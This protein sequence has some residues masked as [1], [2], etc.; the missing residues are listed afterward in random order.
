VRRAE[1]WTIADLLDF[2]YLLAFDA[3]SDDAALRARDRTIFEQ[4]IAPQLDSTRRSGRRFIF[5]RWLS[6]RRGA[7]GVAVPGAHFLAGW[8]TLLT[9]AALTGLALGVSLTAG[10]LHYRGDEP[11]NVSWFL[12]CTLGVQLLVLMVAAA[13]WL[14]RVATHWF[15]DFH[16]LRGLLAGL[17]WLC[18]AGL[19]Q[20]PGAQRESLRASL[21]ILGRKREI[22]GSVATWPFLI[23]TQLFGVTF[24]VGI[25]GTMVLHLAFT[26]MHFQWESTWVKSP[27]TAYRMVAGA[28]LPWRSFAPTPHPTLT[29]IEQSH[30]ID[31]SSFQRLLAAQDAQLG[32]LKSWWPFLCYSIAFYG[33]LVRGLLLVWSATSL[34]RALR[35]IPFD[36]QDCNALL[37]RLTGPVLQAQSE[38]TQLQVPAFSKSPSAHAAG[39]SFVLLAEG[40]AVDSEALRQFLQTN[41]RWELYQT[42][43]VQI[44]HPSGN[45]AALEEIAAMNPRPASIVIGI[46]ARRAPIKAIA[47]FLQRI[48]AASGGAETLI[49]LFGQGA[50]G[51]FS[52]VSEEEFAHWRNFNAIHGLHLG[53]EKWKLS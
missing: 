14:L 36:H 26:N 10:L 40:V 1:P 22:Y 16:P 7:S 53:L 43:T 42:L 6:A 47:L 11:V 17:V 30:N 27:A 24:N 3:N 50:G 34:R 51:S 44:D 37:R 35:A 20:L 46:P 52:P 4:S 9:F 49:L 13:L 2:E 29:E 25:L 39:S 32:T 19:R 12:A 5:R 38:T 48:V 31:R 15:D 8:Q 21:A 33:L 18:S 41:F 23:I 28:A 45:A